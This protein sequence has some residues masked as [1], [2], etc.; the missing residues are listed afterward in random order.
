MPL[1]CI[2]LEDGLKI[3][4]WDAYLGVINNNKKTYMG[5]DLGWRK[6]L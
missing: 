1:D 3:C 4:T 5:F 2:A 6:N